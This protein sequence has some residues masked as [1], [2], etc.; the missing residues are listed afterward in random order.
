MKKKKLPQD[1]GAL[2]GLIVGLAVGVIVC[3]AIND[4]CV[5]GRFNGA[6]YAI[7]CVLCAVVGSMIGEGLHHG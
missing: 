4:W 5:F 7:V 2:V 6:L 3:D 1:T